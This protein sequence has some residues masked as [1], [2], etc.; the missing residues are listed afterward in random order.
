MSLSNSSSPIS[1]LGFVDGM[2]RNIER[3]TAV[4]TAAA[5]ST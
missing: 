1:L 4:N 3:V 5:S 2:G